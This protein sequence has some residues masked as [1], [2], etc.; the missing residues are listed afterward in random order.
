MKHQAPDHP[1]AE[2]LKLRSVVHDRV[3]GL[4]ALPL[5]FDRLR[6][7]LDERHQLGVLHLEVSDLALVESLY[8]WQVFDRIVERVA[9]VVDDAVGSLLPAAALVAL[10]GVAGDRFVIFLPERP[11]GAEADPEWLAGLATGLAARIDALLDQT[12][13][14]GLSPR[15][16]ARAGHALLWVDPFYRF[17][18]RVYAAVDEARTMHE[19]LRDRRERGWA[20][21]LRRIIRD[22]AISTVFQPVVELASREVLGFEALSRGPKGSFFEMPRAMFSV[23][24][25]LGVEAELD[26]LC[27]D[28]ALRECGRSLNGGK[29][30]VNLAPGSLTDPRALLAAVDALLVETRVAAER[31]V[32]EVRERAA[33]RELERLAVALETIRDHGFDVALDDVGTGYATLQ[34]L[35]RVQP[36][37][38]K[39]DS[40]LVRDVDRGLLK[41]ELLRSVI[42]IAGRIGARVIAEGVESEG[43]AA[44]LSELGAQFGQ[45]F[46][47][48]RPAARGLDSGSGH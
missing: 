24:S 3:T 4:P 42:Q 20:Q 46:L 9:G 30:F 39:I 34:T 16:Q 43:E 36:Q 14:A 41:Q 33:E 1:R 5:L 11:D 22:G 23:S 2:W 6:T 35:E 37:F 15:L 7:E 28:L 38:L 21:E 48:A 27:R 26:R 25:R 10:N 19:R 31:L 40:S 13:F 44:T 8:G 47:F 45:G 18:R 17:E 32:F 12:M 29:V